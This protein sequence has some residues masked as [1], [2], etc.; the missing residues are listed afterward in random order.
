[1]GI[2]KFNS[3][4]KQAGLIDHVWSLQELLTFPYYKTQTY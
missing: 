2:T 4:T 1:M 3:P